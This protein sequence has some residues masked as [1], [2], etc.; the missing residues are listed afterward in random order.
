MTRAYCTLFDI[1]YLTRGLALY[2]SLERWSS[3]SFRL[4]AFCM[5]T[6]AEEALQKVDLPNL[7]VVPLRLLE[8]HDPELRQTKS[9]RSQVEYCWTATP[10][11]CRYVIDVSKE[12]TSVTYLDADLWFFSDP[13]VLFAELGTDAVA[14]TPHR[15]APEQR[16]REATSGTYNVSWLTFT[17]DEDGLATL[18][19]WHDRCIEWCYARY[20]DGKLGDQKYLESFPELFRRVHS[21]E[22]VGA[23]LAPWNAAAHELQE[24]DGR[25]LVDGRPVVFYHFHSLREYRPG[26]GTALAMVLG[27]LHRGRPP[28]GLPWE[29]RLAIAAPERELVWPPYLRALHEA[30]TQIDAAAPGSLP[31]PGPYPISRVAR[32]IA[33]RAA[34]RAR[35]FQPLG[36]L[37]GARS[38]Y[39]DTWKSRDVAEQMAT[40]AD[41]ELRRFETDPRLVAPFRAFLELLPAVVADPRLDAPADLIDVGCGMGVYADL[42]D[43]YAPGRFRYL[44]VDY[45]DEILAVARRRSPS[46]QFEHRDLFDDGALAGFD[47]VFASGVLDVM[48]EPERALDTFLGSDARWAILHRQR[49]EPRGGVKVVPGY[50]RQ[51]T[52]RSTITPGQLSD[53]A[54]RHGRRIAVSTVVDDDIHSFALIRD[55]C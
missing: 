15:Y 30:T 44:G 19:W 54:G 9:D 23:G 16:I 24:V 43:R 35:E 29:T 49:I 52:Y 27:R 31:R 10:A 28:D 1:N 38:R 26:V 13:E 25:L 36:I 12:S 3:E 32:A 42:L 6:A 11:I 18:D 2:H 55:E 20:E 53:I 39:V 4:W 46:R 50:Q 33:T 51:R 5:D 17:R 8:E 37:P 34:R 47:V 40:L 14:I 45:S 21:L 41:D 7:E 48:P 22:H